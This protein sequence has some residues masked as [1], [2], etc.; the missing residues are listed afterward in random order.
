M[1]GVE[2]EENQGY[3]SPFSLSLSLVTEPFFPAEWVSERVSE[4]QTDL[5]ENASAADDEPGEPGNRGWEKISTPRGVRTVRGTNFKE[6]KNVVVVAVFS[7]AV[8]KL[9]TSLSHIELKNYY[10]MTSRRGLK[11]SNL[12]HSKT[13]SNLKSN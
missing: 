8:R 4:A 1:C 5:G 2:F 13:C 6:K 3:P 12:R 11:N 10:L 9:A 7:P